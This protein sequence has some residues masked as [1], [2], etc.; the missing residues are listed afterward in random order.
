MTH[1]IPVMNL[2]ML[3]ELCMKGLG[4]ETFLDKPL[5]Q[6]QEMLRVDSLLTGWNLDNGELL[7]ICKAGVAGSRTQGNCSCA[8][9]HVDACM[10][11]KDLPEYLKPLMEGLAEDLSMYECEELAA[12][13]F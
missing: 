8:S 11:S 10:N 13:I 1:Y 3:H 2:Q 6:V 12:A 7:D 9:T 4:W 5:T